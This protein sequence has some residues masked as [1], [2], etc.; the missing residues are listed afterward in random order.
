M[1]RAGLWRYTSEEIG[2]QVGPFP[3]T[4]STC[5][6]KC[7]HSM[8]NSYSPGLNSNF[9]LILLSFICLCHR[10]LRLDPYVSASFH[11]MTTI[12]YIEVDSNLNFSKAIESILNPN[13]TSCTQLVSSARAVSSYTQTSSSSTTPD[14]KASTGC[15]HRTAYTRV[16]NGLHLSIQ[17]CL[18][19]QGAVPYR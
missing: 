10:Y 3:S 12:D 18:Y 16:L 7:R 9:S 13:R 2:L 15:G 1:T 19:S 8:L 5:C 17:S 4:G 11:N 6:T 14:H